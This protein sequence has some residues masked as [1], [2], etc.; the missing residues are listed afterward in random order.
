MFPKKCTGC[1]ELIYA[2]TISGNP[3]P[4]PNCPPNTEYIEQTKIC[5]LVPWTEGSNLVYQSGESQL[6]APGGNPA[7]AGA[8][9]KTACNAKVFPVHASGVPLACTCY[10]CCKVIKANNLLNPEE[11]P[12]D[13][14]PPEGIE[15][16]FEEEPEN[17]FAPT[18]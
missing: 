10:E 17:P 8:K 1:K 13:T 18:N 7:S 12:E 3:L 4:C 11:A 16:N 2:K 5:L 9:W 6:Q 14:S 15:V